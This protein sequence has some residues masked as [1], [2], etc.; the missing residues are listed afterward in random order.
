MGRPVGA[1]IAKDGGMFI[2]GDGW[3]VTNIRQTR[4]DRIS[5]TKG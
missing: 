2:T 3:H 5:K 1:A 4:S